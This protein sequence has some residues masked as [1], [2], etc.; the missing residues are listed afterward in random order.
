MKRRHQFFANAAEASPRAQGFMFVNQFANGEGNWV[1]LTPFGD[2]WNIDKDGKK[3]IQRVNKDDA[4]M[5]ANS[6][7]NP[8]TRVIQPLGMP[9]YIG[10]PDHPRFKG[11]PG[12]TDQ[13]S[14]GRGK[15]MEVRHDPNCQVCANFANSGV[16]CA[17]HG[18]FVRMKWNEEGEH[19][20]ANESFHGHSVNWR[21][22]PRETENGVRIWHPNFIKSVGFTNEPAIPVAPATL[23]NEAMDDEADFN[24]PTNTNMQIPPWIKVLA[25]FKPDEE[26]TEEQLK[27]ALE[28]KVAEGLPNANDDQA[29]DHADFLKWLHEL[30]GTDPESTTPAE[31][32]DKLTKHVENSKAVE[33]VKKREGEVSEAHRKLSEAHQKLQGQFANAETEIGTLTQNFANERQA[34]A[35]L[36]VDRAIREGR[37][38]IG[39]RQA[40]IDELIGKGENFANA[41]G[42]LEKAPVVVK[43]TALTRSLGGQNAEMLA[44]VQD[45]QGKWEELMKAR[46]QEF[47]NETYDQRFA[48]VSA[49]P[50][51][52]G[53][54]AQM[55][56]PR[57]AE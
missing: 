42:D 19:L 4:E 39:Q 35:S 17:E 2:F 25:G 49:S 24:Q 14:K 38:I 6:F 22:V 34:H 15:E 47:A 50:E 46:E 52:Q 26:V 5:M 37:I 53:L 20:I 57:K 28:K 21:A 13:S 8:L 36:V 18:L 56:Q 7:K 30:L 55:A 48:A 43:V 29:A 11:K 45:R 1:Q 9:W 40:K 23:A 32:K 16:P 31:I 54:L 41:V 12:H 33:G 27:A 3:V 44:N 10:H 51:G